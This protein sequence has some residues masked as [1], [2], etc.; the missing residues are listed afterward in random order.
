MLS[1]FNSSSQPVSDRSAI[2]QIFT[3]TTASTLRGRYRQHNKC[4]GP[5]QQYGFPL[6]FNW[7]QNGDGRLY[8]S[9]TSFVLSRETTHSIKH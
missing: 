3:E 8:T 1:V 2:I 9:E 5:A 7:F 4:N 6:R